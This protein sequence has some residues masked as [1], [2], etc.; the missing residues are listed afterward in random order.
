[1]DTTLIARAGGDMFLKLQGVT[2]E[3]SDTDHKGEIDVVSW[4]WGMNGGQIG[5]SA[6]SK[7]SHAASIQE[8]TIVKQVDK[9]SATLMLYLY[10]HKVFPKGAL[11]VRKAGK[12]ALEYLKIEMEQVRISSLQIES[13]G[14]NLVEKLTLGFSKVEVTYTPQDTTGARG[15]GGVVF[16]ADL[17]RG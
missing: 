12:E 3:T 1:M 14:S 6:T 5:P 13:A 11:A 7:A 16:S 10:S 9:A 4:S 15:G 17:E 2:G 8:L